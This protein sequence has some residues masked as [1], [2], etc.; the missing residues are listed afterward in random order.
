[1]Q[2]FAKDQQ[3]QAVTG[4]PDVRDGVGSCCRPVPLTSLQL[5][6]SED[7]QATRSPAAPFEPITA[8]VIVGR[9]CNQISRLFYMA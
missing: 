6:L 3:G 8:S 4:Y 7:P 5:N 1:M 2:N 9:F